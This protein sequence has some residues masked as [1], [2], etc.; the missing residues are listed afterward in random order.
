M[1]YLPMFIEMEQDIIIFTIS[2]ISSIIS[3]SNL[4]LELKQFKNYIL[5]TKFVYKRGCKSYMRSY[6]KQFYVKQNYQEINIT[7]PT[8]IP[9]NTN[10]HN[11]KYISTR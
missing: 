2:I 7:S 8:I 1:I 11:V 6:E 5:L 9:H 3:V 10:L 4:Y